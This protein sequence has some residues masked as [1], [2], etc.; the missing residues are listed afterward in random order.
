MA[1]AASAVLLPAPAIAQSAGQ[2]RSLYL[3]AAR[4]GEWA[5]TVYW[6]EGEYIPEAVQAISHL[7][8]DWREDEVKPFA[9]TTLDIL[10][11]THRLLECKEP[12]T[13]VS[14]YRTP[15]TNAMLRSRSRAVARNS[16][17]MQAMAVDLRLKTRLPRQ[18]AAA[19]KALGSGGVGTYSRRNFVH[20]D[21]GPTRDWGR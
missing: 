13:V 21:S 14:G 10:S 12:F 20:L 11:A 5:N 9:N 16:Y 1:G 19:G 6:V 15:K 3:Y 8:R 17:H 18:I 2:F 7:M 4:T